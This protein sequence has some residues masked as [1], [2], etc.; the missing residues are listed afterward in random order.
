M[1]RNLYVV[2]SPHLI[3]A[4]EGEVVTEKSIQDGKLL[5]ILDIRLDLINLLARTHRVTSYYCD[6][7]I[8]EQARTFDCFYRISD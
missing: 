8:E 7:I 2:A 3:S 1:K 4:Q 6:G 5:E